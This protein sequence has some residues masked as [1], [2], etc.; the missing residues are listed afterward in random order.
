[1]LDEFVKYSSQESRRVRFIHDPQSILTSGDMQ[2]H[3]KFT[4]Y[5]FN[6]HSDYCVIILNS[7]TVLYNNYSTFCI[8]VVYS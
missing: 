2:E 8:I 5:N 1:M 4:M 3:L 7:G 6:D